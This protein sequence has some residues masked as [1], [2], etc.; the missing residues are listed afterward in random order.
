MKEYRVLER[1]K[2]FLHEEGFPEGG[3]SFVGA[4]TLDHKGR[5]ISIKTNSYKTHPRMVEL[6]RS[7]RWGYKKIFLHAEVAALI[8]S[9]IP[10]HTIIIARITRDGEL[11]LAKPCP[12]CQLAIREAKVKR[13]FFT[14]EKGELVLLKGDI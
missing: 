5:I 13:T 3:K 11:A 7:V 4:V 9:P 10:A 12:I 6:S 14:N 1:L 8:N 2:D